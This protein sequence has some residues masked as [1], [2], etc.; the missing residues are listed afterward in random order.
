MCFTRKPYDKVRANIAKE[1]I[2][3]YKWLR[4]DRY[5]YGGSTLVSGFRTAFEWKKGKT[6]VEK[7]FRKE[8]DNGEKDIHQGFHA[9]HFV[10]D[11]VDF[12]SQH[13]DLS[14]CYLYKVCIP[15]GSLY[16]E[17]TTQIVSNKCYLVDD[18]AVRIRK[19]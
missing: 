14:G 2:F 13:W 7:D 11:A 3:A 6:Y 1:D 5:R 17:N 19:K 10:K 9:F 12:K 16:Y 18:K 4:R 8:M 15:K